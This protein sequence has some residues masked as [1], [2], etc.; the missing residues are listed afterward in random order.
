MFSSLKR[1]E[2]LMLLMVVVSAIGS[3]LYDNILREVVISPSTHWHLKSRDDR[4]KG[5]N[6]T[7]KVASTNDGFAFDFDIKKGTPYPYSAI[8]LYPPNNGTFLDFSWYETVT[9]TAY[10]EGKDFESFRFQFRNRD[11]SIY[12][13]A[14]AASVKY[15]T[16]LLKLTA[17]SKTQTFS[18]DNFY[19][20][21]WWMERMSVSLDEARP[22]FDRIEW[23]ELTTGT[24]PSLGTGRVIIKEIKLSGHWIPPGLFYS[25]MMAVWM[26]GG[27]VYAICR[28]FGLKKRLKQSKTM[29]LS[30]QRRTAELAHLAT[31]DPLT[32]LLN[33]RGMRE[34]VSEALRELDMSEQVFSLILFDIDNFKKFNDEHGHVRG[35]EVLCQVAW[36]GSDALTDREPIA[37]WG[38]EEFL[39]LCKGSDA[40]SAAEIADKL[41][42]RF[43]GEL[44]VTCSFGVSEVSPHVKFPVALDTADHYLYMAKSSG[45]N[46]VKVM[47]EHA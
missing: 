13:P 19:V 33:R 31:L 25:S 34:H 44:N 28:V 21:E 32:L 14:D 23:V 9:L 47:L 2:I 17:G 7:S 8:M 36:V 6:S 43:E 12:D 35:D 40:H 42:S 38:G 29:E 27:S 22:R 24:N 41:R 16:V 11:E 39:V 3:L 10:V 45:K 15:N 46:C 37:R 18:K 1:I 26:T 4:A 5:G 30:L 20:P